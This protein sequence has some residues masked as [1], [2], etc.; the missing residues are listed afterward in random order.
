[1]SIYSPPSA[2]YKEEEKNVLVLFKPIP[3]PN[4]PR[5]IRTISINHSHFERFL[6]RVHKSNE[7]EMEKGIQ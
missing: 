1:M 5:N 3:Y 6:E 7:L 4:N 2:F